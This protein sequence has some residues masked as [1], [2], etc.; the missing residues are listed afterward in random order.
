MLSAI[1][2]NN[3]QALMHD[4]CLAISRGDLDVVLITGAEAMY[5]RTMARRNGPTVARVGEP[6]GRDAATRPLR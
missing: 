4:A 6:A 5:A 3:P 1:G 2:G